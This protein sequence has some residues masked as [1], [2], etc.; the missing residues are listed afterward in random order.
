MGDGMRKFKP[1]KDTVAIVWFDLKKGK[2]IGN[3]S[4]M[5]EMIKRGLRKPGLRSGIETLKAMYKIES[6]P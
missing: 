5:R 2:W 6:K 1:N 3:A 4:V